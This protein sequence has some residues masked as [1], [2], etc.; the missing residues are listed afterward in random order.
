ME[1]RRILHEKNTRNLAGLAGVSYK[2]TI[3]MKQRRILY[4]IHNDF[5]RVG[6][7]LRRGCILMRNRDGRVVVVVGGW[8]GG[9]G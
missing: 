3:K 7:G 9:G 4:G 2:F 6:R 5:W 1:P 8:V